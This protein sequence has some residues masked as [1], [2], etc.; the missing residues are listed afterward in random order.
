MSISDNLS[1][2]F[3]PTHYG[4]DYATYPKILDGHVAHHHDREYRISVRYL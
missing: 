2:T 3:A 4:N 1:S